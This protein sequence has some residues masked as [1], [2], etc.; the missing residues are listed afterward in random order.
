MNH[1]LPGSSVHGIFQARKLERVAM[2]SSRGIFP[3]QGLNPCF[4]RLLHWQVASLPLVQLGKPMAFLVVKFTEIESRNSRK[5]IESRMV[6]ARSWGR[7]RGSWCW[8]GVKFWTR[9]MVKFW[10]SVSQ[11]H[12][13]TS[14]H[15]PGHLKIVAIMLNVVGSFFFFKA[16][17][18]KKKT[19][20]W[21]SSLLKQLKKPHTGWSNPFMQS[22]EAARP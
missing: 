11:Q 18:K 15:W 6:G 17:L 14:C 8:I 10:R 1:S 21:L 22:T 5:I 3:T 2:P 20:D 16:Q 4:L 19:P 9:M 13:K 12:K 7:S